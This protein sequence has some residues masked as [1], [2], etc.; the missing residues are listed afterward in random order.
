VP[1][2][3]I[4][5]FDAPMSLGAAISSLTL[6]FFL[7]KQLVSLVQ[8]VTAA[9]RIV[10]VDTA[11]LPAPAKQAAAAAPSAKKAAPAPAPAPEVAAAEEEEV[12]PKRGRAASKAAKRR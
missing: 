7:F 4:A 12:K 10:A 3:G 1:A 8:M 9:Q 5:P 11:A 6:P 2:L